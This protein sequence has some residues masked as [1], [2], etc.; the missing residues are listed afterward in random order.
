MISASNGK[1]FLQLE[2]VYNASKERVFLAWTK[3][4]Q[5]GQW[6][7]LTGFTTTIEQ[8]DVSV[9]GKYLFHMTAPNGKVHTL[10][11]RYV[12][13]IPNEKLSF[14][15]KWLNEGVDSEETL[16]TI[17]FVEMD[18][19]TELVITHSNFSTMKVAKRHDNNW[20]NSL[21]RG[22]CNYIN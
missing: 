9:G 15:W 7:G 3:K 8:M 1:F 6:W 10:E 21:E 16:V 19:K 2:H 17:D 5:L 22:L 4:E 14:T 18:N 11:G 13:I 20:T 12:E